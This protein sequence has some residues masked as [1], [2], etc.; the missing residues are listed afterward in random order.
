LQDTLNLHVEDDDYRADQLQWANE[1]WAVP[2]QDVNDRH[3]RSYKVS[4]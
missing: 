4:K 3:N 1:R 2:R